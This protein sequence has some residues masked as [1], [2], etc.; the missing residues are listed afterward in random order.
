MSKSRWFRVGLSVLGVLLISTAAFAGGGSE[1]EQTAVEK[2][3]QGPDGIYWEAYKGTKLVLGMNKHIYSE[4]LQK[5]KDAFEKKTGIELVFDIYAQDEYMNKRLIDVSSGSGT[6]D[7][8]MADSTTFQYAN[9]GWIEDL[10]PYFD[11]PDLVNK[12]KY[13]LDDIAFLNNY[14]FDNKVYGIPVSG[15]TQIVFYRKDIFEQENL[16]PPTTMEELYEVAKKLKTDDRPGVLVR[17]QKIH[18]VG[19]SSG[20]VFCWGEKMVDDW[21][22][23]TKALFNT[24]NAVEAL[25]FYAQLAR[26]FGPPGIGNYTWYE[27]VSDFQQG[28]APMYVEMSVFMGQFEDPD[29][30]LVAGKVGYAPMPAGPAGSRPAGL[31]WAIA[32]SSA[33]QNKDAAFLF[34][35]WATS[36]EAMVDIAMEGG[37]TTR[38]SVLD[39][40]ALAQKYPADW[41]NAVKQ[42]YSVP[43]PKVFPLMSKA[44][45][46]LDTVGGAVNSMILGQGDPQ[47]LLDEAA[48]KTDTLFE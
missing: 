42:G 12:E 5:V 37:I 39:N 13:N 31:A 32:M 45:E 22:A 24:P 8:I 40:P 48:A 9:A 44:E 29:K 14:T 17:G 36:P 15:E 34:M 25:S 35:A 43:V 6:F 38:G 46:Y 7:V 18:T 20:F 3:P 1:V 10:T 11:N 23:P 30:S 26:E 21:T 27:C 28:K 33:S 41:L 4:T 19:N 2:G 16:T 47:T